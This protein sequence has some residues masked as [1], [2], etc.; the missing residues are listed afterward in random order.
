MLLH[1]VF[2]VTYPLNIV[3][4]GFHDHALVVHIP[5]NVVD[6]LHVVNFD[7]METLVELI[8]KSCCVLTLHILHVDQ[9]CDSILNA[10]IN[11]ITGVVGN[12]GHVNFLD[13]VVKDECA[14]VG[15]D[16]KLHVLPLPLFA[17]A[18]LGVPFG[19]FGLFCF[20]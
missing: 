4:L 17:Y 8:N 2:V 13:G 16:G 11:G 18:Q 9:P 1:K 6:T 12:H 10:V 5:H 14:A 19:L 3:L 20:T 7:S 15:Q